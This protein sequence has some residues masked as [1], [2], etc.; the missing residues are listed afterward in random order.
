M[1]AKRTRNIS[2]R[3]DWTMN[4]PIVRTDPVLEAKQRVWVLEQENA[5]LREAHER[6]LT[7]LKDIYL[8]HQ[9]EHPDAKGWDEIGD[10]LHNCLTDMM[11]E[12]AFNDWLYLGEEGQG[13]E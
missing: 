5:H 11:G 10:D 3:R 9:V 8:K 6:M 1:G 13:D 2:G 4:S 7:V 12:A